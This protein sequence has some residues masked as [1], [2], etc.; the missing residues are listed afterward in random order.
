MSV[1]NNHI[2]DCGA[3]GMLDTMRVLRGAGIHPVGAGLDDRAARSPVIAVDNGVRVGFLAYDLV[4]PR[5]VWAG[6][7]RPGAAHASDN[8]MCRDVRVL[9]PRVDAVVVSLHWGC[10]IGDEARMAPPSEDRIALARRLVEAGATVVVGHHSHASERI[11]RYRRGVICY[12]LGNFVFA[13]T[14]QTGHPNSVI[15]RFTLGR[16][17]LPGVQVIPVLISPERARWSPR[18][19]PPAV[20]SA[21]LARVGADAAGRL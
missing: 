16:A 6:P 8:A 9:R 13:G 7:G 3:A 20:R 10:E 5:S 2:R 18:P 4:P 15:V 21:F 12:G 19:M 1:A 11:E 14:Q 17:T